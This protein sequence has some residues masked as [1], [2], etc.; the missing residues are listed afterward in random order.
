[1]VGTVTDLP[2]LGD[3]PRQTPPPE[4]PFWGEALSPDPLWRL[5]AIGL[6]AVSVLFAL[7]DLILLF[8]L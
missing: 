2:P 6:G 3:L 1:M 5:V 8:K 7:L 4:D